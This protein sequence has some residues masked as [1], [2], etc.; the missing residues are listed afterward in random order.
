MYKLYLL[1]GK[2][3]PAAYFNC[4]F[5]EKIATGRE[6]SLLFLIHYWLIYCLTEFKKNS[7]TLTEAEDF[8]IFKLINNQL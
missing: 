1:R 6:D 2:Y 5:M 8:L 3:M 4:C 7:G